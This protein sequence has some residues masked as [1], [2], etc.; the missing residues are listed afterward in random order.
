MRIILFTKNHKIREISLKYIF[1]L[2]IPISVFLGISYSLIQNFFFSSSTIV[3]ENE[4]LKS[5]L[6]DLNKKINL[7]YQKIQNLNEKEKALRIAANININNDQEFGI[8]GSDKLS[9]ISN[10]INFNNI[11][12]LSNTVDNILSH[13]NF[14]VNNFNLI[15]SKILNE[16]DKILRIP[17]ISPMEGVFA[18]HGFGM[19]L[20]PVFKVWK[21][22]EG[23][24]ILG[25]IG[26]KV[27]ATADGVVSFVGVRGGYG[28]TVEINHGYGYST[29]YAHLS[30][31]LVKVGQNVKRYQT[32]A[33]SGNSG[34]SSGPHL[35]YEVIYNGE[36]LDPMNYILN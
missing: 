35:H 27:K 4:R 19:R 23:I 20:H 21:F 18:E 9:S 22:H 24:D 28:L 6:S 26:S 2:I 29:V 5:E 3:K 8:G 17:A 32:I 13:I 33:E 34:I 11:K 31:A 1:L 15:E 12:D 25:N 30:Q 10:L 36:K 14:Q 7:I 16:K